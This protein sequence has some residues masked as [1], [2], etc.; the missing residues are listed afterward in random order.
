MG[1]PA[2]YISILVRGTIKISQE[3]KLKLAGILNKPVDMLF[4]PEQVKVA[5]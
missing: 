3:D 5:S 1:K 2:T 4:P